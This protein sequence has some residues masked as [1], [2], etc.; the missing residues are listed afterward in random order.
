MFCAYDSPNHSGGPNTAIR[1]LLPALLPFGYTPQ[2]LFFNQG[3]A[4]GATAQ[5]LKRRGVE[6]VPLRRPA[7][8]EDYVRWILA[9]AAEAP[10][11]VFVPDYVVQAYYAGRWLRPAGIPTVLVL[12]GEDRYYDGLLSEFVLGDPAYRV[13]GLV[14]VSQALEHSLRARHPQLPADILVRY[15]PH[16]VSVPSQAAQ[17]PAGSFRLAYVGRLVEINKRVSDMTRAFCRAARELPGTEVV[18]Y[19]DGPSL[20]ALRRILR[21]EGQGLPIQLA[22]NV[23]NDQIQ[24]RLLGH[25]A[26]V[27]LSDSEGLGI[28]LLEAMACGVVPICLRRPSG[29]LELVED[30][31]TGLLV[32]DRGDSFVAAVQRLHTEPGL[33]QRLSLAARARIVAKYS[34]ERS[35]EQWAAF[36]QELQQRAGPR[37]PIE[38]PSHFEL[39]PV[40]PKLAHMDERTRPPLRQAL[41]WLRG[42]AGAAR[43]WW[44][45]G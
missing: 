1:R 12:H 3:A 13:S 23:D 27:L 10:P 45:G 21:A 25:H 9:R 2:V 26:I 17:P 42:R 38:L 18:I 40:H 28:A 31:V 5:A 39:P 43:R 35:A 6:C 19:G 14:C 36:F 8:T 33:W 16:G 37:Q 7:F 41:R 32:D 30:G 20:P 44:R 22:G 11:D 34:Q 4:E 15:I 29:V 24:E